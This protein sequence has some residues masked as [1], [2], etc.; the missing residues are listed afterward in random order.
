MAEGGG[1]LQEEVPPL[2]QTTGMMVAQ[3]ASEG[4]MLRT[5]EESA[6]RGVAAIGMATSP[7]R[8]K[9]ERVGVRL[10]ATKIL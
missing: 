10:I 1:P 2:R 8:G 9:G 6:R 5:L 4:S 3:R 7:R